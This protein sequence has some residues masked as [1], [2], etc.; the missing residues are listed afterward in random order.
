MR[1]SLKT[2]TFGAIATR[3]V[4]TP[5]SNNAPT[6]TGLR[7]IRSP[8]VPVRMPVTA[9]PLNIALTVTPI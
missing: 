5:R 1:R 2:T 7:L 8:N 9:I 3:I 4:G 6:I